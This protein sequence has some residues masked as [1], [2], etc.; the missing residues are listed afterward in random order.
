MICPCLQ[1][2]SGGNDFGRRCNLEINDLLLSNIIIPPTPFFGVRAR[3]RGRGGGGVFILTY[4]AGAFWL[5]R[6]EREGYYDNRDMCRDVLQGLVGG[7]GCLHNYLF[8]ILLPCNI[9]EPYPI[10]RLCQP[11]EGGIKNIILSW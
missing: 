1:I 7:G 10:L 8:F 3:A 9:P 4:L 6:G 2:N 5:C 11:H